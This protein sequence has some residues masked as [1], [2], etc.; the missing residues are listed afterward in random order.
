MNGQRRFL[1]LRTGNCLTV[2]EGWFRRIDCLL[3][4]ENSYIAICNC[5]VIEIWKIFPLR[6]IKF[7]SYSYGVSLMINIEKGFA[8]GNFVE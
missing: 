7:I 6:R 5:H 1:D 8:S 4:Q 3:K 2:I